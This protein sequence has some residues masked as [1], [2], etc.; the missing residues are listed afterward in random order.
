MLNTISSYYENAK[1][2]LSPE[3]VLLKRLHRRENVAVAASCHND[4]A[5]SLPAQHIPFGF[6]VFFDLFGIM[7]RL[8]DRI[9]EVL[10]S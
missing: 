5:R 6:C 2:I 1:V 3:T 10:A 7:D 4:V 9:S 8:I